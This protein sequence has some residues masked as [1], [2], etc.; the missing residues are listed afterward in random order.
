MGIIQTMI[1]ERPD[2]V[3]ALES[4]KWMLIYGRRKTGK[5]FLVSNYTDHDE[6]FFVKRDRT[7]IS[8]KD[9]RTIDYDT[10]IEILNFYLREEKILVIDEFHRLG[11]DFLDQ[12]HSMDINGR[13]FLISSTL[14]LSHSMVSSSSPLLGKVAEL[15]V[16]LISYR[17]LLRQFG[18][19]NRDRYEMMAF[20]MEPL[21]IGMEYRDPVDALMRSRLTVPALVGE[22]FSEED[23]KVGATYEGILRAIAT[24]KESSGTITSHLFSRRIIKKND[25][26]I[27]QQYLGNLM[28]I[29]LI[30]RINVW[31]RK[32]FVYKHNSPLIRAFY[33][34]DEK[35]NISGFNSSRLL[36]S[37][38][39]GNPK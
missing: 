33:Y 10:L 8:K 6:F 26:S 21:V 9:L 13:L 27:I 30:G 34:L 35:Y 19:V 28:D 38:V 7:I 22:I 16:P 3:H 24:G 5:T 14:H 15:K 18:E 12:L 1:I 4:G 32:K 29:G 31:N 37:G 17:D 36:T 2:L 20:S 39:Y 23:R 11:P 25:Q